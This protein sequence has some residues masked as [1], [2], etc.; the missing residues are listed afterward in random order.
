MYWIT[1]E[2]G[3]NFRSEK[4]NSKDEANKTAKL[5]RSLGRKQVKVRKGN[6]GRDWV[7]KKIAY[8]MKV[9]KKTQKQAVAEALNMARKAGII[10]NPEMEELRDDFESAEEAA[11]GAHGRPAREAIEIKEKVKFRENLPMMGELEELEI[12]NENLY[13]GDLE[14]LVFDRKKKKSLV[15]L[16]FSSD[17]KQL[18]LIG[19]DQ[20]LE[21]GFLRDCCPKGWQKD[22]V[23]IGFLY[24]ITYHTD[25]HHLEG[26]DG[27]EEAYMHSFGE[28]TFPNPNA[29]QD[30]SADYMIW[31]LEEKLV[32]GVL[33]EIIYDRLN[34]QLELIGGGYIVKDEGIWD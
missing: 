17:R 29:P 31:K 30:G 24:S 5:L 9:E 10:S 28:Q 18:F 2:V 25:K 22:K 32:A 6:P 3:G 20:C 27:T 12:F 15:R 21:D 7:S 14:Q 23:H 34:E 13:D 33:P 26:S 11:E 4:A 1:Y 8:L 16:G 19:G